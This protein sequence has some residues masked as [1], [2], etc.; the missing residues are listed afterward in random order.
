MS[1]ANLASTI[2]LFRFA[3]KTFLHTGDSRGDLILDGLAAT[4]LLDPDGRAFVD[5]LHVPHNGSPRNVT[6]DFFEKV[7]ADGY[8]LSGDGAFGNP[9]ISTV[10]SLIASRG[11][12]PYTMYFVN[13]DGGKSR[14]A[15]DARIEHG[16][17]LDAFFEEERA[18]RTALSACLSIERTRVT[19]HRSP[20]SGSLLTP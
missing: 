11:D 10:A 12:D 14:S 6:R 7:R 2:L 3:G 20:R 5:L 15:R 8:L 16:K 4:G 1:V 17:N 13:R 19:D 9:E 18:L